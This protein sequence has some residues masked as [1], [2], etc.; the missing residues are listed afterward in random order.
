MASTRLA[1]RAR[2]PGQLDRRRVRRDRPAPGRP[3]R[4]HVP[5]RPV[6]RRG[7]HDLERQWYGGHHTALYSLLF[8]PLAA[9]LGPAVVGAMAAVASAALFEAL[10]QRHFGRAARYGAALFGLGT[11]TLLFTGR[12]PFALGV[13]IGLGALLALQR[14]A[15]GGRGGLA[16]LCSLASPVAGLF[17][18]IA[19]AA[20]ALDARAR[21]Q[22]R[23]G[24][25]RARA[26][27]RP[28]NRLPPPR[29][30]SSS[31]D[32]A[33]LAD[34]VRGR[35]PRRRAR[36]RAHAAHRRRAVHRR[37]R[38]RLPRPDAARQQRR[39][40]SARSSPARSSCARSGPSGRGRL[41]RVAAPPGR[42]RGLR[43][44]LPG[45]ARTPARSTPTRPR[46]ARTTRR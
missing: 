17:V 41:P 6:R 2:R 19:A 22:R 5:R 37:G 36:A 35:G 38:R 26:A 21:P 10:A 33:G 46:S 24:R 1:S 18:A 9:L 29:P 11:G 16:A 8:P 7:V 31:L 20:H 39:R 27:A 23:S 40:G 13:A 15:D 28:R 12:M 14:S 32:R 43:A 4:R 44:V 25:R 42:C 30:S 34:R 45:D 3:G